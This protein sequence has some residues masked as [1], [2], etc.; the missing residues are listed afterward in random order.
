MNG[1]PRL[2]MG[3]MLK[4]ILMATVMLCSSMAGCLFEDENNGSSD[5]VL[6]V[7]SV[8][9]S[10]NVRSGDTVTFD[11]SDSTPSDGSLTY[12]WNFDAVNS[13]DIDATGQQATWSFDETGTFE[14]KLEVSDGM[15]T[16]EQTREITIVE[17]SA[18]PPVASIT[19]YADTEDSRRVH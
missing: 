16:S 18:Q 7:F 17:A 12:R 1:R 2:F 8:S 4:S 9:P 5:E 13:I 6:A 15:A 10:K 14:V 19:Q 11:A 3:T